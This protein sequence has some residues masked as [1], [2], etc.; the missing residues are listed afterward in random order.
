MI[1]LYRQP[2]SL[3][4]FVCLAFLF[5]LIVGSGVAMAGAANHTIIYSEDFESGFGDWFPSAGEWEVG[6]P[7]YGPSDVYAGVAC[8]ATSLTGKYSHRTYSRLQSPWITLPTTPAD[9]KLWLGFWHWFSYSATDGDDYGVVQI[10]L[11]GSTWESVSV[12]YYKSSNAWSPYYVDLAPYVG[13]DIKIGFLMDDA[14]GSSSARGEGAGWYVDDV[15][16][17]DG[18]FP[19]IGFPESF[20]D[21][22]GMDWDGWYA[23]RG[24]WEIGIPSY[25]CQQSGGWVGNCAATVLD[26]QYPWKASSR[27]ISP[28][29]TLNA[30]PRDGEL[31]LSF[32]EWCNFG[33]TDGSDRGQV[34]ILSGGV[35]LDIGS[36]SRYYLN[37]WSEKVIDISEYAGEVVRFAF[38]VI[39]EDGSSSARSEGPGWFI[40]DVALTEG[41]LFMNNLADCENFCPGWTTSTMGLW[42]VGPPSNGP[43]SAYSGANCW[44]TYLDANYPIRAYDELRT[45]WFTLPASPSEALVL[46][47]QHWFSFSLT[48]GTDTGQVRLSLEDGSTVVLATFTT[49]SGGTWSP[50]EIPLAGYEGQ[51]V[52]VGFLM[53]DAD[54]SSSAHGEGAG[55]FLDDIEVLGMPHSTP[56]D[57][58]ALNVSISNGPAELSWFHF[59]PDIQNVIVYGSPREDF[60]PSVGTRLAVLN[61]STMSYQDVDHLAWPNLYYRVS[62]VDVYGHESIPVTPAMLSDVPDQAAVAGQVKM[63]GIFPNPFN[64]LTTVKFSTPQ[65]G[66][67]E[68]IVYDV[69]GRVVRLLATQ[70]FEAGDHELQWDGRDDRGGRVSSGLY[71]CIVNGSSGRASAKMTLVK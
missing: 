71:F 40:D 43:G 35:W 21:R 34:Q 22:F 1:R 57:P 47:F 58:V 26:G 39:D 19:Q 53:D 68:V 29:V 37:H 9:G 63:K 27:L 13:Q 5:C 16:V 7:S 52:R 33:S 41:R 61:P 49:N 23:D 56:A 45:P 66:K 15:K 4:H 20:E 28:E 46:K 59:L 42:Q 14:D 8:A 31:Y 12:A 3:R 67:A 24:V 51:R 70:V 10:S 50:Y 65:T 69:S 64:P 2:H 25:G 62:V 60:K 30:T 32:Q 11:D 38:R 6:S 48:D 55:W 44:G 17:F 54:G 36:Q 18:A